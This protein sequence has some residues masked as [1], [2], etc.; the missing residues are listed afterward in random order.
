MQHLANERK[1][2]HGAGLPTILTG[3]MTDRDDEYESGG[4]FGSQG[5]ADEMNR[6]LLAKLREGMVGLEHLRELDSAPENFN[7]NLK[8]KAEANLSAMRATHQ[9][10]TA[11]SHA[12]SKTDGVNY[13]TQSIDSMRYN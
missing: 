4:H 1:F 12:L 5:K 10:L 9:G 7:P 8:A 3:T 13:E 11:P 2:P 6:E